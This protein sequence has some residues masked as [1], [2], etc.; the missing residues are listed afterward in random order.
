MA[1]R[2]SIKAI[3][4]AKSSI[5]IV[6]FRFDQREVE[7]ALAAAVSRGVSVH[8]LIAHTNRAGEENL[9]KLEM[10]LLG[11]GITV[12]R[13]ADDLVRYHG[14]MMLIDRRELFLLAFNLTHQDIDRSRSFG[15]ITRSRDL[16]RE[17]G[18]L[19]EADVKR[20][21]YE[22][23][24]DQFIVS[25]VNARKRLG[26]F[27]KGARK[28][29][30]IYDPEVS[31]PAMIAILEERAQG[32]RRRAHHRKAARARA[33]RIR[34]QKARHA[35]AYP[36]HHSRSEGRIP[37]QPEPARTGTRFAPRDRRDFSGREDGRSHERRSSRRIGSAPASRAKRSAPCREDR[38][39][40][41]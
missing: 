2:R 24:S 33:D 3:S 37:G 11:S 23:G 27:L 28:R 12:A 6:I 34:C 21:P 5:E 18:R 17:A 10:R 35:A 1:L 41:S 20:H 22:S 7:R 26:A 9:R 4:R 29:L 13:T 16:V 32:R 25:P 14:K 31:D 40:S 30:L 15:L 8:A 36:H 38:K 39:E 19:F